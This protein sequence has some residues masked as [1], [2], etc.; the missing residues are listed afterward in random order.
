MIFKPIFLTTK[1]YYCSNNMCYGLYY[2]KKIRPFFFSEFY[3]ELMLTQSRET[4]R[5][6]QIAY[7]PI[8]SLL[9]VSLTLLGFFTRYPEIYFWDM[10]AGIGPAWTTSWGLSGECGEMSRPR[11]TAA[12]PK[13]QLTSMWS[14]AFV[15]YPFSR[16][17]TACLFP[18]ILKAWGTRDTLLRGCLS[19]LPPTAVMPFSS[20][21]G[22]VTVI[23]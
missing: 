4:Q 7:A 12:T 22:G 5:A 16:L 8:S 15:D 6:R 23:D 11:S 17:A 18:A 13:F 19:L 10:L 1:L 2:S 14:L 3:Q 9:D 21:W 20:G